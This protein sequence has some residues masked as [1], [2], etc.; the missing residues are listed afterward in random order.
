MSEIERHLEPWLFAQLAL[1]VY[2]PQDPVVHD[3]LIDWWRRGDPGY[4]VPVLLYSAALG[5]T[6]PKKST[7]IPRGPGTV[8]VVAAA[9]DSRCAEAM[10]DCMPS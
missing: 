5:A 10:L 3:F 7:L 4:P 1:V 6:Q 9:K 8:G 2:F